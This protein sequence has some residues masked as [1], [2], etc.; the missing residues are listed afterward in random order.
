MIDFR[1]Y[2]L[3]F[4]LLTIFY[5]INQN[6]VLLSIFGSEIGIYFEL[7]IIFC[8][9]SNYWCKDRTNDRNLIHVTPWSVCSHIQSYFC[10]ILG[11]NFSVVGEGRTERVEPN[12]AMFS[13]LRLIQIAWSLKYLKSIKS[14]KEELVN[15]MHSW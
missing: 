3:S 15:P 2:L 8:E 13:F 11:Y 6:T 12:W 9:E 7:T 14:I 5:S 1:Q 4:R 10:W